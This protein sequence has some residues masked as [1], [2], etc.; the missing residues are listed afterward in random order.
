MT[1]ATPEVRPSLAARKPSPFK[2]SLTVHELE[3]PVGL[4]CGAT[5]A[6]SRYAEFSHD[7]TLQYLI[8][9]ACQHAG[10]LRM[11]IYPRQH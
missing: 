8:A 9:M 10:E 2:P 11:I 4:I 5:D 7:D 3:V 1:Q 6:L